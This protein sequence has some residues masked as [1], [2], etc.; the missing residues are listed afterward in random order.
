MRVTVLYGG[1][2]SE[3][4]ISLVS[5]KAVASGLR[6]AG[7]EVFESDVSPE[8]LSGLDHPCDVVFPVLHGVFGE[9]G[10][11]QAIL[12][13]RGL[14]FVGSGSASSRIAMD[15]VAT[16]RHWLKHGIPTPAFHVATRA[17]PTLG[18]VIGA[19]VVK[20]IRGGSSIGV[21]VCPNGPDEAL[22]HLREIVNA[23]GEALVE[24]FITGTEVTIGILEER[25]LPPI[26][27]SYENGFFDFKA[28]YGS[29]GAKHD[30]ETGLDAKLIARIQKTVEKGHAVI[31]CRDLSR[32]DVMVDQAT[33]AFYLLE[34]NTLP[35]FT[36]RSLLPEAAARTGVPFA[37]LVDRLARRTA[38]RS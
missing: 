30:F 16:K 32:T 29:N 27:I 4:E 35:G 28:K 33:Q 19:C 5:G 22:P 2:S 7:H 18:P 36:P 31:G 12:E 8:N 17:D 21:F 38:A 6:E 13:S 14:K 1:P 24:Q 25:A 26:R 9:D 11:L 3:R 23:E 20:S 15:K 34:I 10:T 37:A